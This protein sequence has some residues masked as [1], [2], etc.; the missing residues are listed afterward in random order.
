MVKRRKAGKEL[1]DGKVHDCMRDTF[2]IRF[3]DYEE[4]N[5]M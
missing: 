4:Y 2:R 5:Y 1:Q 3:T